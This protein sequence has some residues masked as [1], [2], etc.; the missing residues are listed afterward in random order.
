MYDAG[1][2][3]SRALDKSQKFET[4]V[5]ELEKKQCIDPNMSGLIPHQT[6][7]LVFVCLFLFVFST[8]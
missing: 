4:E 5:M 2:Y 1:I 6:F 3:K 7:T 8:T